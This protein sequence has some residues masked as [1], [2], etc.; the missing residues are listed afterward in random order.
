[1]SCCFFQWIDCGVYCSLL[2]YGTIVS[3]IVEHLERWILL[4]ITCE[5]INCARQGSSSTWGNK[6]C[7]L[8][9]C[10]LLRLGP[11]ISFL[12]FIE[13]LKAYDNTEESRKDL[14][15]K[16]AVLVCFN[17]CL[18]AF[19][20]FPFS[21]F[22]QCSFLL[23]RTFKRSTSWPRIITSSSVWTNLHRWTIKVLGK[24][25]TDLLIW[26]LRWRSLSRIGMSSETVDILSC[27]L[28]LILKNHNGFPNWQDCR[29]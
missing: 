20:D 2:F 29:W 10:L 13:D 28:L 9:Q 4:C 22:V 16:I 11:S 19:F 6:M 25:R 3:H 1:V 24:R 14:L 23:S 26:S 18:L 15:N 7:V 21:F 5:P 27:L 12:G 17:Y 8:Y